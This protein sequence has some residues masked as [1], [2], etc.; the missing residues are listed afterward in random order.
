MIN[1]LLSFAA[2]KLELPVR[3]DIIGTCAAAYFIGPVSAVVTG[4]VS[5]AAGW[6]IGYSVWYS[7]VRVTV[8]SLIIGIVSRKAPFS[9]LSNSIVLSFWCGLASVITALPFDL[10]CNNGHTMNSWGDACVDMLR[11]NDTPI[12]FASAAGEAIVDMVDIQLCVLLFHALV[13]VISK[14]RSP[15]AASKALVMLLACAVAFRTAEIPVSAKISDIISTDNC[16]LNVYD[17]TNGMITSGANTISETDDGYIWIGGYAGLSRYDGNDFE[18][19]YQSGI[20]SVMCMIKDSRGRLWIGTNE[21]GIIVY[22]NGITHQFTREDGLP[23]ESIRCFT[24]DEQGNIYAGTS[25]RICRITPDGTV[26]VLPID[27][28]FVKFMVVYNDMLVGNDNSGR[29]FAYDGEKLITMK[30]DNP[31]P[32]WSLALTSEGIVGGSGDGTLA[33]FSITEDN[34]VLIRTECVSDGDITS[35]LEDSSGRLWYGTKTELGYFDGENAHTVSS[36]F[37]AA[38]MLHEDYQGNIWAASNHYGVMKISE[39]S[40]INL[41]DK[42]DTEKSVVNAVEK[43]KGDY[44][45][46]TDKGVIILDGTTLKEK[47]NILTRVT[48]GGRIRCLYTDKNNDL[49]VCTYTDNG[50]IRFDGKKIVHFNMQDSGTTSDRFRCITEL[51]DGTIAAGTSDGLNLIKDDK[52]IGTFTSEDGLANSQILSVVQ[53]SDGSIWAGTDGSGVYTI[54]DGRITGCYTV[55]DGLTSNIIMKIIPH[56]DGIFFVTGSGLCHMDMNGK[57]RK[58]ESFPFYDNFDILILDDMAYITCSAGVYECSMEELCSDNASQCR[59]YGA[60]DGVLSGLTSN[61]V[62]YITDDGILLMC[63]SS[64]ITAFDPENASRVPQVKYGINSYDYGKGMINADGDSCTVPEGVRQMTVYASVRSYALSDVKVR[65]FVEGDGNEYKVCDKDDIE[66]L[67]ISLDELPEY[68]VHF[69]ILDSKGKSVLDEKVFTIERKRNPWEYTYYRVYLFLATVEIICFS[70]TAILIMVMWARRK[71]DLERLSRELEARVM[72]QTEEI[73]EQQD[74]MSQLF[75]STVIALSD[76]VDAKDRY[77][78]GHS[79]RVAQYAR[80][81]AERMGKSDEELDEIYYAGLLHDVGKIRIP[82]EIINKTAKL[83]DEEF[84]LIKIHPVT[85]YHILKNISGSGLIP[86]GA[87]FHH[88]RYDGRGYPNGLAGNNIPEIARILCVADSYDAMASNRSYRNALPQ[89]VVRQELVKG[90]GTQFDPEIA[91]I[92]LDM[93]D[94]DNEYSMKQSDSRKSRILVVDDEELN[95]C[96][97]KHI[98]KNEPMYEIISVESGAEAIEIIRREGDEIDMVL[99]DVMMPGMDGFETFEK[100]RE[101]RDIPIVFMT[102]DKNVA[103]IQKAEKAGVRDFINKPLQPLLLKEVIHSLISCSEV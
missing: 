68:K 78:S 71:S 23:S 101:I 25:D 13:S 97:I 22:E 87:K 45:C 3:L 15:K 90:R 73:R 80:M 74:K 17:N 54:S 16:V 81:I 36:T 11:W 66:P 69:Q 72:Q 63:S 33:Y 102:G 55:E 84:E 28:T 30:G 29:I 37:T 7:M 21:S 82:V 31:V 39:S 75:V 51:N 85:G 95:I 6:L 96:V 19:I 27:F 77:T 49:W 103:T 91:D 89:E 76:A 14:H 62:N 26:S 48:E 64:G 99:M 10:M 34:I 40:F 56:E 12:L 92:M 5:S 42:S 32:I 41:F 4:M 46:G 61:S 98:M 83:T 94:A 100:I 67:Y 65:F 88:E 50:L 20:T 35:L 38:E 52:V 8:A 18:F 2:A 59:L 93:M 86:I 44:Y 24:E 43:Y 79:K 57:I 47:T 58:L 53:H 60:A 9:S 70:I 1:V